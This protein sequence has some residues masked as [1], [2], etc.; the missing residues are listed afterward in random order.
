MEAVSEAVGEVAAA[1]GEVFDATVG[2]AAEA[3]GEA[4]GEALAPVAN[5]GKDISETERK[6][7]APTI[8]A[9]VV[10][11]QVAQSAVAAA[12]TAANRP[13]GRIGK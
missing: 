6:E 1:V 9:A 2:Q 12:A 5:L 8:I 4:V 13:R 11:T 10:I 3:I 7:A